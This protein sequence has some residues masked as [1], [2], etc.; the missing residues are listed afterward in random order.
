MLWWVKRVERKRLSQDRVHPMRCPGYCLGWPGDSFSGKCRQ[1]K[2]NGVG[3]IIQSVCNS[4]ARCHI[5][6]TEEC[7]MVSFPPRAKSDTTER[8]RGYDRRPLPCGTP[9]LVA[10]EVLASLLSAASSSRPHEHSFYPIGQ[11]STEHRRQ[12]RRAHG[13]QPARPA[14]LAMGI[15]QLDAGET[16][17]SVLFNVSGNGRCVLQMQ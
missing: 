5:G 8:L 7:H 17:R 16:C 9:A 15:Q 1:R 14:R 13:V 2:Q 4:A 3:D 10:R 6:R 11:A 12:E